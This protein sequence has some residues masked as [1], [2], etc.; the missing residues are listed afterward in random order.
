MG[1]RRTCK[2]LLYTDLLSILVG[3]LPRQER[4]VWAPVWPPPLGPCVKFRPPA[5]LID[6]LFEKAL[7]GWSDDLKADKSDFAGQLKNVCALL[8]S[9]FPTRSK[10]NHIG[11]LSGSWGSPLA[12]GSSSLR[13]HVQAV[14]ETLGATWDA[15]DDPNPTVAGEDLLVKLPMRLGKDYGSLLLPLQQRVVN[16]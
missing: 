9:L 4:C 11:S 15:E 12:G 5:Q 10:Q 1:A 8:E 13:N 7:T 6:Q 16:A 3:G 2:I 14:I